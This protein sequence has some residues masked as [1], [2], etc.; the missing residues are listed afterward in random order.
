[1]SDKR[2]ARYVTR[3]EAQINLA[4]AALLMAAQFYPALD[5]A[6]YLAWLDAQAERAKERLS[7]SSSPQLV[8]SELNRLLFDELGFRG[9][10]EDY[11]DARNSFLNEVIDRRTG[12]P[13][14]LSLVFMEVAERSG[15]SVD[16]V[17]LPGHFIVRMRGRDWSVLL[18]PF[19][20]GA[21]LSRHD[22]EQ[23]MWQVFGR[24]TPL[25]PHYLD[26][27][28]K[29]TFLLRMANNLQAV[30]MQNQAWSEAL[31]VIENTFSLQPGAAA[32][33]ELLRA[34]GLIHFKRE[35]WSEAERDWLQYLT[36]VPNAVDAAAIRQNLDVLRRTMARRN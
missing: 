22:C 2:F 14:T 5:I 25:L 9:N 28:R 16:G 19:N 24:A 26:A 36:M 33:A 6:R 30:F 18:D 35:E 21:E 4:E 10:A 13:I 7:P 12:I 31:R 27:I 34:R 3:P 20:R 23:L 15:L 32:S 17:G 29:R 1:M 11:Y 8:V